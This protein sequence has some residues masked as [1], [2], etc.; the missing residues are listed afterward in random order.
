MTSTPASQKVPSQYLSQ[1]PIRLYGA[2]RNLRIYP[3]T[4]PQVKTG[5]KLVLDILNRLFQVSDKVTISVS[6]HKILI[7]GQSLS[8]KD[9]QR[10]QVLGIIELFD[11]LDIH[12]ITFHSHVSG[13]D[14]A[15]FMQLFTL[16]ALDRDQEKPSSLKE[17]LIDEEITSITIDETRYVAV[18]EGEQVVSDEEFN[19]A[20]LQI[21]DEELARFVLGSPVIDS[22][23]EK[24]TTISLPALQELLAKLPEAEGTAAAPR[25][26][27]DSLE[28]L[29]QLLENSSGEAQGVTVEGSASSWSRLPPEILSKLISRLPENRVADELLDKTITRLDEVSLLQ[30]LAALLPD[31]LEESIPSD[32]NDNATEKLSVV[33]RLRRTSMGPQINEQLTSYR[34][35]NLLRNKSLPREKIPEKLRQQ[36]QDPEWS[37]PVLIAGMQQILHQSG[38]DRNHA[39]ENLDTL[40]ERFEQ[41]VDNPG[42]QQDIIARAADRI[43]SME[44]HQVGQILVQRFKGLFGRQLYRR[45]IERLSDER[46]NRLS[47]DLQKLSINPGEN[48]FGDQDLKEAYNRLVQS[49]REEKLRTV[50]ELHEKTVHT[51][52][53][54]GSLSPDL[55]K[56][57][58]DLLIAGNQQALMHAA[59]AKEIPSIITD[60]LK[61]KNDRNID[62]LLGQIVAALQ[63]ENR[64]LR[65]NAANALSGTLQVLSNKGQ[66]QRMQR[67][68]PAL[69]Q[70]IGRPENNSDILAQSIAAL[71]KLA[72]YYIRKQEYGAARDALMAMNGPALK[73]TASNELKEHA[74]LAVSMLVSHTILENL[75]NQYFNDPDKGEEAG[76]L[77]AAF[78]DRAAEFLM[79]PLSRSESREERIALLNL[80]EN[81]GVPAEGALRSMLNKPVPWYVTRNIIRLLGDIGNPD[82]FDDIARF[83]ERDDVRIKQE[84]LTAIGKI[85]GGKR[86]AF[87]LKALDEVPQMLTAQVVRLLGDIPDDR[88]VVPLA[89]L[90]DRTS[91]FQSKQ[92]DE[93]QTVICEAL[94]KIGSIK[95]LP[96][97][98]KIITNNKV[99]GAEENELPDNPALQA[100]EQAVREIES[101]NNQKIH[102]PRSTRVMGVPTAS[103]PVAAR[104]A[105]IFRIALT[106]DRERALHMLLELISDCAVNKDFS[107]A[108]RL[109]ER[110]YEIDPTALSEIIQADEIIVREKSGII[111]RSYLDVWAPLLDELTSEEFSSIY[112]ELDNHILKP[113][114]VLVG[115]GDKNDRLYFINH[116]TLKVVFENDGREIFIKNL[117]SGEIAGENFFD[118]SL[119]TVTIGALTPCRVSSLKR[120]SFIRW[121]EEF[122]GLETKLK[123]FYARSNNIHT[124]LNK[125]GLN[126]R[127]FERYRIARRVQIQMTNATG[128]PIGRGFPG[129]LYNISQGGLALKIRIAKKENGRLLLGRKMR[130]TIPVAEDPPQLHV[131]GR[132]LSI[133]PEQENT[134]KFLVHL[135]FAEPLERSTLQT[136]LG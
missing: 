89:D 11:K 50:I 36:L 27:E 59:V 72:G 94:G 110:F 86:K 68:L 135:I 92:G 53:T 93:L 82:C 136:I 70:V 132:T 48:E 19:R 13:Q 121:Q 31:P 6:E 21:S 5:A 61:R 56:G 129:D 128:K 3:V 87:L 79:E 51:K 15:R 66:W 1:L 58:I 26:L 104:E 42:R 95:A 34:Y 100:A 32:M 23:T 29:F 81:I 83:M 35:A 30:L 105:A 91:M 44:D 38:S 67:L 2:L 111:S 69:E 24:N 99:P 109:R 85:G 37:V 8:D 25:S 97:L 73:P 103:D 125:K 28:N 77:L 96:T 17:K 107:N 98:K 57:H 131:H 54:A 65:A 9:Q 45:V 39:G 22:T 134:D 126:R 47:E 112:H 40:F 7:N 113:E 49:V 101:G 14:Y 133:H 63:A 78:G 4:N 10:P 124:L 12:S 52:S 16:T 75:L 118:A 123:N 60:L 116:G 127:S 20:S 55:V 33:E 114:E 90:L 119:W 88:L 46:L 120:S 71:T 130:I 108:E 102:L 74:E 106:G 64:T 115:R 18:S 41:T 80:I 43:V 62:I 84:V 117:N 76:R 122:P